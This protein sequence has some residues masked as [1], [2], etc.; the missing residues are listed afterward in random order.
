M[1]DCDDYGH[2]DCFYGGPDAADDQ[3]TCCECGVLN[4]LYSDNSPEE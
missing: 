2:C 1:A 4:P 3:H